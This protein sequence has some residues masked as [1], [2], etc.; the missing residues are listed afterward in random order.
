M[1][2]RVGPLKKLLLIKS[3]SSSKTDSSKCANVCVL[4]FVEF[5]DCVFFCTVA[6]RKNPLLMWD[7]RRMDRLFG[8]DNR[9]TVA[10]TTA[11]LQRSISG[12]V[13]TRSVQE[14]LAFRFPKCASGDYVKNSPNENRISHRACSRNVICKLLLS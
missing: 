1:A 6:F 5:S 2:K 7:L 10:Q 3:F 12:P 8:D 11:R 13:S 4:L 9:A 14:I